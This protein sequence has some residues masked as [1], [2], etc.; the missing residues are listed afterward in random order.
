MDKTYDIS[1]NVLKGF[2][3]NPPQI[4]SLLWIAVPLSPHE[5]ADYQ[6]WLA[7]NKPA[8]LSL[9]SR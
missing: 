4:F 3:Q 9:Q 1:Y 5:F 7:D 8:D 6:K 2:P